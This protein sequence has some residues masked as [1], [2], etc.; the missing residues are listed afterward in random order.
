MWVE[1]WTGDSWSSNIEGLPSMNQV[2]KSPNAPAD[3]IEEARIPS[4]PFPE[5]YEPPDQNPKFLSE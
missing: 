2:F 1:G 5:G 4:E 3:V